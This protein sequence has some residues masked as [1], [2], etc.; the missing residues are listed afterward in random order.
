V[1]AP[2]P[3]DPKR[4]AA[5][6]LI[7]SQPKW[8]PIEGVVIRGRDIE[9]EVAQI[10][11]ATDEKGTRIDPV[12]PT[13]SAPP[14]PDTPGGAALAAAVASSAPRG[15]YVFVDVRV[16]NGGAIPRKYNSW[17]TGGNVIAILA[18]QRGEPLEFV[19]PEDTP[20]ITRLLSLHIPAGQSI[21]D[22]LVFKAPAEPFESLKLLLSPTAFAAAGRNFALDVPVE[23]LFKRAE[24]LP[25]QTALAVDDAAPAE[26]PAR[27][28][29]KPAD[30]NAPPSLE[31][32]TRDLEE[33]KKM[34]DK[35]N[36]T[37]APK[38]DGPARPDAKG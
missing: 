28:A 1:D 16:T 3:V 5:R 26:G 2:A 32:F 15:K 30:P 11:L 34:L 21:G 8:I 10:W 31:D 7:Q 25:P 27:L 13:A 37:D 35:Q 20:S 29:P 33:A 12:L 4:E 6:K 18:D 36:A 23:F 19:P 24:G 22:I 17:N 38:K 9:V 14:P